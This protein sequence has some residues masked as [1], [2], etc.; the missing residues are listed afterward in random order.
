MP[1]CFSGIRPESLLCT[2]IQT[3][4]PYFAE[5]TLF[6]CIDMDISTHVRVF[7]IWK[8]DN[9][10]S[11]LFF[12]LPKQ[13]LWL[14]SL[15]YGYFLLLQWI[16][17][18]QRDIKVATEEFWL[19]TVFYLHNY[20]VAIEFSPK[21]FFPDVIFHVVLEKMNTKAGILDNTEVNLGLLF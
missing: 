15:I 10:L 20:S 5:V 21:H 4:H 19:R 11:V 1:S 7:S 17:F 14:W 2:V 3:S 9:L 18:P 12:Y 6:R 16:S 13:G 8:C